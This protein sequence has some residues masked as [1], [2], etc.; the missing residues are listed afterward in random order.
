MNFPY[1]S[2]AAF[3]KKLHWTQRHAE[4]TFLFQQGQLFVLGFR[5]PEHTLIASICS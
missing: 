3:P 4:L 2:A 5:R 1:V